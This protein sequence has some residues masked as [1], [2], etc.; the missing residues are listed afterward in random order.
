M[1]DPDPDPTPIAGHVV[2]PIRDRLSQ[3]LVFE[4]VTACFLGAPFGL[5]LTP[6]VLEIPDQFL[7]FRIHRDHR[8]V[9]REELVDA[10]VDVLKLLI[11]IRV[12]RTLPR[13]AIGL[14]A[15]FAILEYRRHCP[16]TDEMALEF[17]RVGQV[18]RALAGP[19]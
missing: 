2:D 6:S 9:S 15:V 14:E 1:I 5:I 7:L 19:S 13:L 8:L 10:I 16:G 3:G 17:S 18:S 11:A 4:V 12:G